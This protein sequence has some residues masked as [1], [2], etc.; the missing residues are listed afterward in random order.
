ME[1]GGKMVRV[2]SGENGLLEGWVFYRKVGERLV[3][4]DLD[5]GF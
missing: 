1:V 2:F 3:I 5:E 4:Q